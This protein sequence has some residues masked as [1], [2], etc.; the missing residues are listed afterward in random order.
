MAQIMT[1]ASDFILDPARMFRTTQRYGHSHALGLQYVGHGV[2]WA[3]LAMPWKQELVG[4]IQTETMATGAIIGLLDMTAGV[5]VWTR[6]E[7][8][9]PQATLD[10]RID[11]LRAAHPRTAMAARVECYRVT[12]EIAFVR[13]IA[14]DG[15]PSDPVAHMAGS[16]MFTGEPMAPL[17]PPHNPPANPLADSFT[18]DAG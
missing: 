18:K 10:L 7:T 16:F 15:D 2:G 8:F 14:H 11:Y 3:E 9:R 4:D 13:G 12:H 6:L 5:S 17:K 1:Q